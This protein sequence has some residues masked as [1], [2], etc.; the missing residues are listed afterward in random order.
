MIPYTF[1]PGQQ[2]SALTVSLSAYSF[3]KY[4][5]TL[6]I[7]VYIFSSVCP[8]LQVVR[9]FIPTTEDIPEPM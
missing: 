4:M 7:Y 6:T 1:S 8:Y 5:C 2:D 9:Y 3:G